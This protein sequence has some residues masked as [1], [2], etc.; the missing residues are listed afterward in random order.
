MKAI[1]LVLE[2]I[3][4]VLLALAGVALIAMMFVV[5]FDVLV[6]NL[7][8]IIPA[9][10]D[11][12]YYGTIEIVRYLFLFA[13]AGTMPWGV[14]KSQVVVELFTQRFSASAQARID[15]FFLLGYFLLGSFMA[16]SL[17]IAGTHAYVTGE[18][19]PDLLIPLGPIRYATAFCM[20]LMA[21]R[22]L[23]AAIR[24]MSRGAAHVA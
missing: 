1:D 10:Q 4:R 7:S 5:M 14:E 15:A 24:G 23:L 9:L 11:L 22:A 20:G 8:G 19:T 6:R 2:R 17:F 3:A 13:M 16:Y 21:L 12:K 18:T